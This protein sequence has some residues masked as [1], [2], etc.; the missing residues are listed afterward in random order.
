M[1]NI[2][3]QRET[4]TIPSCARQLEITEESAKMRKR[5]QFGGHP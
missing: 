2:S 5:E 3:S 1:S 4:V